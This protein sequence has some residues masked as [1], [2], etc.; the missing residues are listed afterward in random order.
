M[1]KKEDDDNKKNKHKSI[2]YIF[3]G[4]RNPSHSNTF[5]CTPD[6]CLFHEKK[7]NVTSDFGLKGFLDT[8]KKT[9]FIT[10]LETARRIY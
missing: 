2:D 1:T 8:N 6:V 10:R 7:L 4:K 9:N 3:T 5:T